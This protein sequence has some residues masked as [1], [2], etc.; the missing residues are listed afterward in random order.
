M[1]TPFRTPLLMVALALAAQ[2]PL[3]AQ[4]P[5]PGNLI[6][7]VFP[8]SVPVEDPDPGWV[9]IYRIHTDFYSAAPGEEVVAFYT[10]RIGREPESSEIG[11]GVQFSWELRSPEE[12]RLGG[13]HAP[14]TATWAY[15]YRPARLVIET[16]P[17]SRQTAEEFI[18]RVLIHA[19][20]PERIP[21]PDLDRLVEQY[22]YLA[23]A[24][25]QGSP[26][27]D[28]YGQCHEQLALEAHRAM[29]ESHEARPRRPSP[30]EATRLMEAGLIEKVAE[31]QRLVAQGRMEEANKLQEELA[32]AMGEAQAD[33]PAPSLVLDWRQRATCLGQTAPYAYRTLIRIPTDPAG[34]TS[35]QALGPAG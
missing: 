8:G 28:A 3:Y 25:F 20:S 35:A 24:Y 14:S 2:A 34:W 13:G 21:S 5:D 17:V 19:H 4:A 23:T 15:N 26:G 27:W 7:P 12:V 10:A 1:T 16:R 29:M 33:D 32:E 6:A 11:D 31:L 18:K 9:D 22:E 30:D